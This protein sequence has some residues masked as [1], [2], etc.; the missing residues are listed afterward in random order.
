MFVGIG[1]LKVYIPH[2]DTAAFKGQYGKVLIIAGSKSY[3]GAPS[4]A[5]L[6]ALEFGVDLCIL[7]VP[8]SVSQACPIILAKH[9]CTGSIR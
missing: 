7:M 4:F 8:K 6:A 5:A 1:D 3:S 2:R 9:Y